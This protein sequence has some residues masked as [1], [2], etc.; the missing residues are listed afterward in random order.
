MKSN[1]TRL[2]STLLLGVFI[3]GTINSCKKDFNSA[4]NSNFNNEINISSKISQAEII[5]WAKDNPVIKYLELDYKTAKQTVFRGKEVIKIKV[6][7]ANKYP[8]NTKNQ[9]TTESTNINLNSNKNLV[10]GAY[11]DKHPPE[12]FLVKDSKDSIH[13]S[14][15]NFIP[16]DIN[17]EFGENNIWTGKLF[18]W[19]IN[20]DSI[21]VQ[22]I[23]KNVLVAKYIIKSVKTNAEELKSSSLKTDSFWS[24]I[25]DFFG[26]IGEFFSNIAYFMGLPFATNT[27]YSEGCHN[28]GHTGCHNTYDWF[29]DAVGWIGGLFDGGGGGSY[30]GGGGSYDGGS[31][32]GGGNYTGGGSGGSG[33]D[34]Y[35]NYIPGYGGVYPIFQDD[36]IHGPSVP[37]TPSYRTF[38]TEELINQ[39][40]ITDGNII[41]FLD[42]Y[43]EISTALTNYAKSNGGYTS[44]N[45]DFLN[46]AMYYLLNNSNVSLEEFK[47]EYF[48]SL[49]NPINV[50]DVSTVNNGIEVAEPS[51]IPLV[52][53]LPLIGITT[54]RNNIEDLTYGFDG[55]TEGLKAIF[56]FDDTNEELSNKMKEVLDIGTTFGLRDVSTDFWNT[57]KTNTD[58]N[59]IFQDNRLNLAIS[60]NSSFTDFLKRFGDNLRA[61]LTKTNGQINSIPLIDLK[62]LRPIFGGN[63]NMFHGLTILMNDTE[64]TEIRL[65]KFETVSGTNKFLATVEV[66]IIDHFGVDKNDALG[67]QHIHGGFTAWWLLQHKRGKVPFI[68]KSVIR[69]TIIG[70]Y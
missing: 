29:G 58:P 18:E 53:Q 31:Y 34:F 69:K 36:P 24:A 12:I 62:N 3:L 39:L 5:K 40:T 37:S 48:Y 46:W 4:S 32:A 47:Q 6:L 7:N 51:N 65:E 33:Y 23:D 22:E 44:E 8:F 17:K 35:G 59:T 64:K 15:L 13:S 27:W 66:T 20:S 1:V 21:F 25:G 57:F 41:Q 67:K 19:N 2:L 14:M 42:G 68:T 43:P 61:E 49:D 28:V 26:A 60:N 30:S 55:N 54:D 63:Y 16:K 10:S 56:L 70:N 11:F 38:E 50:A 52:G 9:K 45:K